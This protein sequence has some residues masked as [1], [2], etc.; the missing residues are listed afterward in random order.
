LLPVVLPIT[1][2]SGAY[3]VAHHPAV[4]AFAFAHHP[5]V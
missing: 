5:A 3:C 4:S 1:L 2:P